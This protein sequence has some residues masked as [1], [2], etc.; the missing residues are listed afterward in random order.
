MTQHKSDRNIFGLD[1]LIEEF[2]RE[3]KTLPKKKLFHIKI[4]DNIGE[5]VQNF[6]LKGLNPNF[7]INY[8]YDNSTGYLRTHLIFFN[9][10]FIK[11]QT[12]TTLILYLKF[13]FKTFNSYP[14]LPIEQ[15]LSIKSYSG[16]RIKNLKHL[17]RFT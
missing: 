6:E 13:A 17:R 7:K 16:S 2:S 14:L 11:I 3:K 5:H 10:K 8:V 15:F 12:I 9:F 1:L 4:I